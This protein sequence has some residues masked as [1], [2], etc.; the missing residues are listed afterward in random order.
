MQI[1]VHTH[2]L[3]PEWEDWANKHVGNRWPRLDH[4]DACSANMM[5]GDGFFRHVTDQCWSPER[6]IED[7]DRLGVDVQAISPTPI[8]FCYWAEAKACQEFARMQNEYCAEVVSRYPDRF[9]GMATVPLQ[10]TDLAIKELR[11]AVENLQSRAVEIGSCPAGIELDSPKLFPFFEACSDLGVSVLV[12]PAAEIVGK[13]RMDPYY[14]RFIVGNQ[15]ETAL[16]MTR[17]IFGGVAARL[18]NLRICFVHGGGAFPFLLGRIHHGWTT[19]EEA[20]EFTDRPPMEYARQ[21]YVDT[22]TQS[23]ESLRYIVKVLGSDRIVMGSD[24]PFDMGEPDPVEFLDLCNLDPAVKLA[25]KKT[26][27]FRFL[28]LEQSP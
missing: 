3:P 26:N 18:Q 6:R 5:V 27:A 15:L 17:F 2:F 21:L 16:A 14:L 7:M 23:P 28:G 24:Y 20:R 11:Y 1:D 9:K 25:I 8:M 10:D 22:L 13:E 4:C 12:H 19:R